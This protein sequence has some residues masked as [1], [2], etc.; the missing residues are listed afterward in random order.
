MGLNTKTF[1]TGITLEPQSADPSS[2]SEGQIQYSDGTARAKGVWQYKNGTWAA[3][4][5]SSGSSINYIL[6]TNGESI[7]AWTTYADA[8][9]TNPVDGTGGSSTATFA[10]STNSDMRG[11]T[12]F[13]F[14]HTAANNQGNGFSYDFT[15]DPSDKSKVLQLSLEY[16]IASGTYADDDLQFWIY[17]VTNAALIQPAPYKLKNSGI[18]EKFAMEFQ[19]TQST[20]YR[21][22]GHVATS[23]ATAYTI[24]FT[25]WNLGPQA[26]LYGSPI[27]DW[28]TYTPTFTGFGT[29]TSVDFK[30]KREGSDLLLQGYFSAG[31]STATQARVSLPTGLTGDS[32]IQS[33]AKNHWGTYVRE[34]SGSTINKGGIILPVASQNYINFGPVTV[35]GADT[36]STSLTAANGDSIS[37]SGQ[38]ISISARI[39]IAGWSSSQVMSSDADTRV[40]AARATGTPATATSNNPVIFPTVSFDYD[41][42]YD[43]TTGRYTVKKPGTYKVATFINAT[44]SGSIIQIYKNGSLDIYIGQIAST[45]YGGGSGIVQCVAGDILDVRT[46]A[47]TGSTFASGFI[48]FE[49]ISGPS[50]IAASESVSA[51]Y[52]LSANFVAS[53][54]TPINFDSKEWD[55]HN[56]VTT[57][58]TSWKFTA[59]MSGTYTLNGGL[60]GSG[61]NIAV[62]IY[63]N[64]T[65]LKSSGAYNS[66]NGAR[67][68]ISTS[69]KLLAGDYIDIRTSA[70]AQTITGGAISVLDTANISIVRTGNY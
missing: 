5:G 61:S 36:T 41:S 60:L 22:I 54:T 2:P 1:A 24:R 51:S 46:H 6:S 10:V 12:N 14:T 48:S 59:P 34:V 31:T 25:N 56:A 38:L 35:F 17:D 62:V 11:T 39:P 29:A 64:G 47:G 57:S 67:A 15:I 42:S 33:S 50:Q 4:A 53:T 3:I 49:R 20:S 16:K 69:I 43:N 32:A 23:T 26:K 66:A 27:T 18:I 21:L 63:K 9:G 13:L 37:G 52:W 44:T 28:I 19:T 65:S 7:G 40:V 45:G 30:W 55:S 8:A 68:S 70:A 58:A